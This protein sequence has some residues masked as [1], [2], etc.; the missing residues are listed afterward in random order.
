VVL[1]WA[2]DRFHWQ[3]GTSSRSVPPTLLL[4]LSCVCR[5]LH[6]SSTGHLAALALASRAQI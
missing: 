6:T 4:S 5:D 3:L 1:E 2:L